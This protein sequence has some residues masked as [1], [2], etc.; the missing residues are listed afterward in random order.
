MH[1]LI[2]EIH[3]LRFPNMFKIQVY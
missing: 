1:F 3:I 2:N